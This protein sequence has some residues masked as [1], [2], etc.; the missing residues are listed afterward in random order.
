MDT[1]EL[2]KVTEAVLSIS[3]APWWDAGMARDM[4][5]SWNHGGYT[6][7]EQDAA[8]IAAANPAAVLSLLD[9]ITELEANLVAARDAIR[10]V[11]VISGL[12]DYANWQC[13]HALVIAAARGE[14]EKADGF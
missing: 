12:F 3:H 14:K 6:G 2:R 7:A 4:V 5:E 10:D 8:F 11:E 9:L 1:N 13:E